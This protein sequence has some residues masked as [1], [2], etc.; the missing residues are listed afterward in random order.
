MLFSAPIDEMN[1]ALTQY[2]QQ[3]S[4]L[5]PRNAIGFIQRNWA[6]ILKLE[7]ADNPAAGPLLI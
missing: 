6:A 1:Q 3:D 5:R 4:V 2:L 7:E